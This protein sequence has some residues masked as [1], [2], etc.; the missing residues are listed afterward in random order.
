MSKPND[1]QK[2]VEN[3]LKRVQW[4]IDL[5]E[6]MNGPQSSTFAG[7]TGQSV[8]K[9]LR[10]AHRELEQANASMLLLVQTDRAA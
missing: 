9:R 4:A 3:A 2:S 5:I 6:A 10:I 8:L 1:V 7:Y